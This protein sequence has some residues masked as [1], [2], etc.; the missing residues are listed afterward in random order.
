LGEESYYGEKSMQLRM[1]WRTQ[2]MRREMAAAREMVRVSS[3][4]PFNSG[5]NE[6]A[7]NG[8]LKLHLDFWINGQIYSNSKESLISS[9]FNRQK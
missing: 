1:R 3:R 5:G 4:S 7:W 9:I 8:S 6:G 2:E